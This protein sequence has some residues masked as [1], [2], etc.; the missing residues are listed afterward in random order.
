MKAQ[1]KTASQKALQTIK[2]DLE[3]AFKDRGGI[4]IE[5]PCAA[6][7]KR[8]RFRRRSLADSI[9]NAFKCAIQSVN[10]LSGHLSGQNPDPAVIKDDLVDVGKWAEELEKDVESDDDTRTQSDKVDEASST[11]EQESKYSQPSTVAT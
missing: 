7:E 6:G 9:L 8:L 1:T 4:D 10:T 2:A 3:D 5:D 11:S